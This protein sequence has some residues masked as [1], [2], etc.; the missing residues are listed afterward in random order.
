MTGKGK[1]QDQARK[2]SPEDQAREQL[3]R[4]GVEAPDD[5]TVADRVARIKGQ[6]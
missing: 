5:R 2:Q 1:D 3:A 4:E 6:E